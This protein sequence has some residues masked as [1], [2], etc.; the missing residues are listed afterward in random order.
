MG[1][2]RLPVTKVADTWNNGSVPPC[3]SFGK[4]WRTICELTSVH[5][6]RGHVGRCPGTSVTRMGFPEG[7]SGGELEGELPATRSPASDRFFCGDISQLHTQSLEET[8]LSHMSLQL[9]QNSP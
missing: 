2:L 3:L 4:A 9:G 6:L 7:G 8:T 1:N 5:P